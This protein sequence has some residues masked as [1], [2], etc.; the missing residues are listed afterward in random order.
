MEREPTGMELRLAKAMHD[1]H[2]GDDFDDLGDDS[3]VRWIWIKTARAGIH[4]MRSL[5]F[6]VVQK[7]SGK[8]YRDPKDLWE[9]IIDAASPE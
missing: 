1:L 2:T 9:T 4:E 8:P 6:D 5:T 3:V 7:I